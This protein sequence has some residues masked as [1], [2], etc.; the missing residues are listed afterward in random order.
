MRESCSW[1]P[2]T[3]RPKGKQGWEGEKGRYLDREGRRQ[4]ALLH[5]KLKKA[6]IRTLE[7]A[8]FS[9]HTEETNIAPATYKSVPLEYTPTC[10]S[11]TTSP[12]I[13]IPFFWPKDTCGKSIIWELPQMVRE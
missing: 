10:M 5:T 3:L 4:A 2:W 7:G 6:L 12:K 13:Y 8:R 9:S 1:T 11:P